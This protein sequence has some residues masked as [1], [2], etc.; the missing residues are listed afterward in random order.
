MQRLSIVLL[1]STALV[2][3]SGCATKKFVRTTVNTSA[4]A[5]SARIDTNEGEIKEVRDNAD[6][7]ISAVDTRV[8]ALDTKTTEGINGVKTDV[9]TVKGD[10]TRVDQKAGQAQTAA[11]RANSGVTTVDQKYGQKFQ[12]RNLFNVTDSKAVQFKFDSAKL[13]KEYMDVLDAIASALAQN[14]NAIVVLEGRT[15]SIGDKN[16]NVQLGER[17]VEA[18]RRYLAVEKDVPVYKIHELSLGAEKPVAENKTKDGREKN[19]A[20]TMT[21]M[22]PKADS[23]VASRND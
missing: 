19:R 13:D 18:V 22:V 3:T 12:D 23:A 16:Y 11:D 10:V 20:V 14:P 5:L 21:I 2:A 8:T 6:K 17:R 9:Q 4:D 1:M 7:K 15:D